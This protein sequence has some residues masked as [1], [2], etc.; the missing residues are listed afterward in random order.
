MVIM[1]NYRFC[2][3]LDIDYIEL[4]YNSYNLLN[5]KIIMFRVILFNVCLYYIIILVMWLSIVCICFVVDIV[6]LRVMLL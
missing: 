2:N 3:E 1:L 6:V 4:M 5:K